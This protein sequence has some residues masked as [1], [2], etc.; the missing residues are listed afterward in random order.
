M[1]FAQW[2]ALAA[3]N[4]ALLATVES[5]ITAIQTNELDGRAVA[6]E[7]GFGSIPHKATLTTRYKFDGGF[8]GERLKWVFVGAAV[9][10]QSKAF[11]QTDTRAA[12]AGGTGKDY[13]A[14]GTLFTD[15]FAGYRFRLPWHNVPATVQ[16]NGRNIFNS[17]LVTLARYNADFSGARRIYLRDPRSLRLTLT[18]DY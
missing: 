4:P 14:D 5:N 8:G 6:Q 13:Y 2:R 15:A 7:Q 12:S 1:K 10:Y 11:S 16:V 3:G 18:L 9:R 17:D